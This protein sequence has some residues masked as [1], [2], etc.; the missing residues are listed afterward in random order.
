MLPEK[1]RNTIVGLT[2]LA[3]LILVGYGILK[4]G[5]SPTILSGA[6]PYTV[7]L[8]TTQSNGA[9]A[10]TK[11]DLNGVLIGQVQSVDLAPD[12]HGLLQANILLAIDGRYDIPASTTATIG[13]QIGLG[14]SYISLFATTGTPPFLPRDGTGNLT[15]SATDPNNLIPKEIRDDLANAS[16]NIGIVANDLHTLLAYYTPEQINAASQPGATTQSKQHPVENIATLVVRLNRTMKSLDTL[17]TDPAMHNQIREIVANLH[18]AS[19]QLNTTLTNIDA[20]VKNADKAFSSIG[21]IT[22]ATTK[23]LDATQV[24]VLRVSERLVD[25]LTQMEKTTKLIT[26]GPGTTGKLIND[27]RLYESLIDLSKNL[28]STASDLDFLLRKWK[29]EGVKLNLK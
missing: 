8:L 6:R 20:T 16:R 11:V 15:A 21:D 28:S 19:A 2:L 5:Q 26:E 18:T 9:A 22:V 12:S 4:L 10:G 25:M 14:T 7:T 13:R 17:L 1:S 23:T 3:A 29:D 27:P 24:Q